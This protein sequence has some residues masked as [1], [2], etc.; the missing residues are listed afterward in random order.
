MYEI[1]K[2]GIIKYNINKEKKPEWK[3]DIQNNNFELFSIGN[4]IRHY[5]WKLKNFKYKRNTIK[6][7]INKHKIY[8]RY[9]KLNS[10][11]PRYFYYIDYFSKLKRYRIL[12][13]G[14]Y[15]LWQ[16][17]ER[18]SRN[19]WHKKKFGPKRKH[20][21][22]QIKIT[23]ITTKLKNILN[24]PSCKELFLTLTSFKEVTIFFL[25]KNKIFNKSRYS[26]N[27]QN[28]RTGV[29][30]ILWLNIIIIVSIYYIFYRFT[31]NFGFIWIIFFFL[32]IVSSF[33]DLHKTAIYQ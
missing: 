6:S 33:Q 29:Y 16:F 1:Y 27:R 7:L 22:K 19:L 30:M 9:I 20:R 28:Y 5:C 17:L 3:F 31:F 2:M 26:R 4:N 11:D 14:F 24:R 10:T 21:K 15:F 25:R 32:L 13:K 18:L 23:T 12:K 8:D